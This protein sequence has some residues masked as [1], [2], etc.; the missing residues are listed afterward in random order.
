MNKST[1]SFR[2]INWIKTKSIGCV[3]LV[4]VLIYFSI[5][6]LFG[7][8]YYLLANSNNFK[9]VESPVEQIDEMNPSEVESRYK[10]VDYIY[11]SFITASTI[12]YGDNYPTAAFGKTLVVFQSVFCSV[13]IAVMMSIITSKLLWPAKNTIPFPKRYYTIQ[14]KESFKFELLTLIVCLL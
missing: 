2:V 12:G 5:N 1:V 11:F 6:I 7:A 4:L 8:G 13:Y 10:I 3:F 14:K 9:T